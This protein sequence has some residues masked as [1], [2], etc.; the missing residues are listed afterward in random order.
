M[1]TFARGM[2]RLGAMFDPA[3]GKPYLDK[4][5]LVTAVIT[6]LEAGFCHV[7]LAASLRNGRRGYT[8]GGA[9]LTAVGPIL[10]SILVVSGAA[11]AFAAIPVAVCGAGGVAIARLFRG[12]AERAQLGLERALDDLERRPSSPKPPALQPGMGQVI[13]SIAQDVRKALDE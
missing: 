10:G 7:T 3:R 8:A 13:R 2:R 5:Q 1:E 4:A 11:T 9:W 12:V 6:P